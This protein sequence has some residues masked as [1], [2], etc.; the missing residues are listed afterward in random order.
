VVPDIMDEAERLITRSAAQALERAPAYTQFKQLP[1][2]GGLPEQLIG[3]LVTETITQSQMTMLKTL[4]DPENVRLTNE[5]IQAITESLLRHM[6][7]VGTEE[8]VKAML[9][10]LLE[11]QKRRLIA[12]ENTL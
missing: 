7:E 8:Q 11:E 4:S 10:D 5:L 9:I 3:R 12:D 6:A 2:F 1:F